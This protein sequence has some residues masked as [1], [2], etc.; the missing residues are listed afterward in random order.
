MLADDKRASY[1]ASLYGSLEFGIG[2]DSDKYGS[3][4]SSSICFL[5]VDKGS[6]VPAWCE[7]HLPQSV[8]SF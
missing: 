3:S 8:V 6:R 7:K 2:S 4:Q 5:D 1:L